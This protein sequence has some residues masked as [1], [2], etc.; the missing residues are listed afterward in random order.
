MRAY[1][2]SGGETVRAGFCGVQK[3][4]VLKKPSVPS[5]SSSKTQVKLKWKK[6]N[7]AKKYQIYRS[8]K[9]NG[10]Y[11][12]IATVKNVLTYK[13]KSVSKNKTY[14]YKIRAV[15]DGTGGNTYSSYSGVRKI[16]TKK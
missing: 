3:T 5:A 14:Y 15:G 16:K 9:K 6:I 10:S 11:K 2:K 13:D 12:K 7:G 4:K 1:K 8:N